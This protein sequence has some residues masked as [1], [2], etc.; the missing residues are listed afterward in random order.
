[1]HKNLIITQ[2][3]KNNNK[4]INNNINKYI[5]KVYKI[6]KN[7]KTFI[8][9]TNMIFIILNNTIIFLMN[10]IDLNQVNQM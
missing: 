3:I 10:K 9:K 6:F 1:M 4:T 2:I 7:P 8:N 5:Y